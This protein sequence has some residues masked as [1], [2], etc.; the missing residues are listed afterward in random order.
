M[1]RVPPQRQVPCCEVATPGPQPFLRRCPPLIMRVV[2][3]MT[4]RGWC[5]TDEA[6]RSQDLELISNSAA[7][8]PAI[9]VS[10]AAG[11]CA[12]PK[13]CCE[14][15]LQAFAPG[16]RNGSLWRGQCLGSIPC[17]KPSRSCATIQAIFCV[18]E[19][20]RSHGKGLT[21]SARPTPDRSCRTASI[22]SLALVNS[23]L[24]A[25]S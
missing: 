14:L 8:P 24:T 12:S 3:S 11:L 21:I 15:S 17:A 4:N 7:L 18:P 2:A 22:A 19:L 6:S 10:G 1:R 5:R 23:A 9:P 25:A 13:L 20:W 16:C